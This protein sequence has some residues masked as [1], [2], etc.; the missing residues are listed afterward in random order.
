MVG[1]T[2]GEY[3][4]YLDRSPICCRV[5]KQTHIEQFQYLQLISL[6][7]IGLWEETDVPGGK[8]GI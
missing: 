5:Q 6:H 4:K 8:P 3:T 1:H 7:I 2:L